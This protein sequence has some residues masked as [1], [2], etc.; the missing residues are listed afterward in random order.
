[1]A[2]IENSNK[3][4]V[5]KNLQELERVSIE[6]CKKIPEKICSNRMNNFMK[7]LQ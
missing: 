2:R 5:T 3:S 7:G 6:E 4:S 1:M